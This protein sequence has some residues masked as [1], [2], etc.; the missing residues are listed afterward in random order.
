MQH[1][2]SVAV[3]FEAAM[4]IRKIDAD[5]YIKLTNGIPGTLH[6]VVKFNNQYINQ[7]FI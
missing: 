2:Y 7:L 5:Q 1:D 3:F 6:A 4:A